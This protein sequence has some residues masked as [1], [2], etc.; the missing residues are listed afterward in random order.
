MTSTTKPRETGA[1][2]H[3]LSR[4]N[5]PDNPVVQEL[6]RQVAN[7]FVLYVNYKHYHWQA[8]GPLFRDLHKLF[9]RLAADVLSTVD[10]LA[11]RVRMIGQDPPGHLLDAANLASVS[12]AAVHSN[13]RE[14]VEEAD[15]QLLIVISE[16]RRG[17]RIANE[18]DDPGTVDL[19]SRSVQIHEK[20][21]W[22][23]RDILRRDDGLCG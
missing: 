9:D 7:A 13:M 20:H 17:A 19:F 2:A 1:L 4:E 23:M 8:F 5:Y 18:H 21:E 22:W 15:R 12:P 3:E 10:E 16:L 6:R 14:M 11:E